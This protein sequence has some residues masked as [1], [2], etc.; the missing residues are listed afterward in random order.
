LYRIHEKPKEEDI[1]ELNEKL[2]LFGV[3]FQLKE[4]S[5]KEFEELLEIVEKTKKEKKYFIEISILRSLAE[6]NYSSSN[7]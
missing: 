6:A 1:L 2:N 4:G 7:V 5:T 3:K